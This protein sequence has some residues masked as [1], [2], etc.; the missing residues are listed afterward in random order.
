MIIPEYKKYK[1]M[2]Y[3]QISRALRTGRD[4][5]LKFSVTSKV[6]NETSQNLVV[7]ISKQGHTCC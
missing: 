2:Q 5:M 1:N 7:T 6:V 4:T 3:F